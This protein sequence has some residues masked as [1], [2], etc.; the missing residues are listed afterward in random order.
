MDCGVRLGSLFGITGLLDDLKVVESTAE[1]KRAV[2]M[3]NLNQAEEFQNN[4]FPISDATTQQR[5][6]GP[7]PFKSGDRQ[8]GAFN[9]F[10][11]PRQPREK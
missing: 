4:L 10:F 5:P 7:I 2:E 6:N 3:V 9:C 8:Q 11:S 1:E